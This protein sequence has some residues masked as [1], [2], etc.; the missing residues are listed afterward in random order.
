[1]ADNQGQK[2]AWALPSHLPAPGQ[3]EGW[4]RIALWD[5]IERTAVLAIYGGLLWRLWPAALAPTGAY[6]RLLLLS[7]GV[8]VVLLLLRAPARRLARRPSAWAIAFAGTVMP[9]LVRAGSAAP[10]APRLAAVLLLA[11]LALHLGAKLSLWRR[12]GVVPADRGICT[13]GLYR[14]VRHPMYLGYMTTHAG[15]LLAQ[16]GLW[17]AAVYGCGWTLLAWRIRLEER[18]LA[19][20]PD[21]CRYMCQTR[22]RLLPG[23]F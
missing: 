6:A 11:G 20:N 1:M 23:L 12:F 9:L 14:L 7:E 15:F 2:A 17:N 5:F 8:V 3:E 4:R 19:A 22:W 10:V 16:P 13:H 18:L 21:Y